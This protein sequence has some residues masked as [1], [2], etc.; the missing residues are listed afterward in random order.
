MHASHLLLRTTIELRLPPHY[1]SSLHNI[2]F[3]KT[4]EKLSKVAKTH[5]EQQPLNNIYRTKTH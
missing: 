4:S 2:E 5:Q 1:L 3:K